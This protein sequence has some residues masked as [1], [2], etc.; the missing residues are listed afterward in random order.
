LITVG[1]VGSLRSCYQG[2]QH[3]EGAGGFSLGGF[4]AFIFSFCVIFEI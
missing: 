4:G 2:F 3:F 1:G